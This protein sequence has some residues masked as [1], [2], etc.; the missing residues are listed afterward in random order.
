[1]NGRYFEVVFR[2]DNL[3]FKGSEAN[4]D[5]YLIN[6]VKIPITLNPVDEFRL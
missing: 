3:A 2:W 6:S 5:W 1:M 4:L